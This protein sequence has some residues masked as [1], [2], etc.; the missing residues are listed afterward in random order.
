ME[1]ARDPRYGAYM[2]YAPLIFADQQGLNSLM[3]IQNSGDE[4][5]TLEIWFKAQDNCLR[6]MLGDVLTLA[7]GE[8]VSFDPN[9]VVGTGL[10]R[11]RVDPRHAAAGHRRRHAS[12]ATTSRATR[13]RRPTSTT[14]TSASATR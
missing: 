2:Y 7:P 10:D 13:H 12:A 1:G 5:S 14:S 3:Y 9:T 6:S 8:T 4:C 11:Q